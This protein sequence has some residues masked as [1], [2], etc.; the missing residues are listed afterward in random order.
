MQNNLSK[1]PVHNLVYK[2]LISIK[3]V[4][5]I[6]VSLQRRLESLFG[7]VTVEFSNTI[8]LQSLL[9]GLTKHRVAEVMK[10]LKV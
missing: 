9:G 8:L 2:E 5:C 4:N 6:L 3:D 1:I 10:V 7:P